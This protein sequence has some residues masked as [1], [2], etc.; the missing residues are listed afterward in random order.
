M[1]EYFQDNFVV[2]NSGVEDP[3]ALR[4]SI[5]KLGIDN[6]MWAID[7]PYQPTEPAVRFIEAFDCTEAERHA[8]CHGNAERIF[9]ID[10][11]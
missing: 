8:L 9:H 5:D 1:A 4:Y 6:V 3:L 2:T 10:P 7:Y 11:A